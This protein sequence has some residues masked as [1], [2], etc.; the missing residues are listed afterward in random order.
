MS[1]QWPKSEPDY[2]WPQRYR[3]LGT[4][5]LRWVLA[6]VFHVSYALGLIASIVCRGRDRALVIRTDGLGDAL[7][8]EPAL[9]SLA[10]TVSPQVMHLWAPR[11]TRDLLRHD[12]CVSRISV[13]PRGFKPGNLLVFRSIFWRAKLGL[14]LGFWKFDKVIYPAESPE[15]LGNWL[16]ASARAC[17]RWLNYGDT[18]NQFEWQ[19][20]RAHERATRV[21]ENRPGNAHE[22]VRNEY[23]ASQWSGSMRLRRPKLYITDVDHERAARRVEKWRTSARRL[24]AVEL[25]GVVPAASMPLN[26]YPTAQWA[27]ALVRLWEE[28][29]A[30]P[31][32]LGGPNDRRAIAKLAE[33]LR[34]RDVPSLRLNDPAGV[35]EM[36]ATVGRLD[37]MLCVDTGL[38]HLAVAQNVPT[39][40]LV[41]G[42]NPNRFF[43]WP[44]AN[45][46]AALNV[47]MPCAG[48]NNRCTLDKPECITRITPDEIVAAYARLRGRRL[49]VQV[50]V[51][52]RSSALQA[53]G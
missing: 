24:G 21:I 38:A 37:G 43:P 46:H 51:S 42:G 29:R 15:P 44:Q 31:V 50:Y 11:L 52:H 12:P 6:G 41:S 39:V 8:F 14:M 17:E 5:G 18:I 30:M 1:I 20:S 47:P 2:P 25:I 10:R 13:I 23:L 53:V 27:E 36:A 28:Q 7:L 48:C 9:E 40:V 32:L 4:A 49:A 33:E 26:A 34:A 19:Q 3:S 22:L 35:L 16:F 45:H